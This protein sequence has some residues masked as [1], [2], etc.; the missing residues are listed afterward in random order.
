MLQATAIGVINVVGTLV[1]MALMDR[2]GRRPLLL[3]GMAGIVLSL[4]AV[5]VG[6]DVRWGS[7]PQLVFLG[8]LG[9]VGSFALSLGPVNVKPRLARSLAIFP[10]GSRS[11]RF[12]GGFATASIAKPTLTAPA[13]TPFPAWAVYPSAARS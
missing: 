11:L 4:V 10:L 3:T 6:F 5:G 7:N 1:A 2:V 8:L 13:P 12:E 9:F